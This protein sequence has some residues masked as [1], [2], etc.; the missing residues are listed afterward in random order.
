[1]ASVYPLSGTVVEP[2]HGFLSPRY[3]LIGVPN[4]DGV[5]MPLCGGAAGMSTSVNSPSPAPCM[6]EVA[7]MVSDLGS[8][9]RRVAALSLVSEAARSLSV[10]IESL[11]SCCLCVIQSSGWSVVGGSVV[12][13]AEVVPL[14]LRDRFC[15]EGGC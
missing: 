11:V 7:T 12:G 14:A 1:M 10:P 6:V 9:Y 3:R 5:P 8:T 13:R 2:S 15:L 4:L